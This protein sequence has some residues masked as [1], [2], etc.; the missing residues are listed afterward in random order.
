MA[1]SS[2]RVILTQ[3]LL[4]VLLRCSPLLPWADTV[5]HAETYMLRMQHSGY[6]THFRGQ[7]LD[8][9]LKAYEKIKT[10]NDSN[11]KPM[12][13]SKEWKSNE[14][15]REKRRKKSNWCKNQ[16]KKGNKY[17]SVLLVP[18]STKIVPISTHTL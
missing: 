8:S 6:T 4:R 11:V 1:L 12:Y 14:R 2:K 16:N 10:A 5:K 9:A 13:R 15:Q 17:K 7:V 18:E 3:D